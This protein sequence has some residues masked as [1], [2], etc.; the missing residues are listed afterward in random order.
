[1]TTKITLG[2]GSTVKASK[3]KIP[4]G[5]G[6]LKYCTLFF[7]K[8]D[9]KASEKHA[10][11]LKFLHG[12]FRQFAGIIQMLAKDSAEPLPELEE[13]VHRGSPLTLP[14]S[15][16]MAAQGSVWCSRT[17]RCSLEGMGPWSFHWLGNN[18]TLTFPD[19]LHVQA[20][21]TGEL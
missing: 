14:I 8:E 7:F 19:T 5:F 17:R 21:G 15:R 4:H 9:L 11:C 1:M 13:S 16:W 20:Y 18:P 10:N 6:L 3:K 2:K 12:K